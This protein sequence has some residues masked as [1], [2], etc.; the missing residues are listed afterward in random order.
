M[1]TPVPLNDRAVVV[2]IEVATAADSSLGFQRTT[3]EPGG[4]YRFFAGSGPSFWFVEYGV[5]SLGS[6]LDAVT[7]LS[8]MPGTPPDGS[9]LE[10]GTAFV[11]GAGHTLDLR[12]DSRKPVNLLQLLSAADAS[13]T[14]AIDVSHQVLMQQTYQLPA[15]LVALSLR[16]TELA[17]GAQFDWPAGMATTAMLAPIDPTDAGALTP[18]GIN[19]ALSPIAVYLLTVTSIRSDVAPPV[20]PV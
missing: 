4:S 6:Q 17:P 3:I 12:N 20:H 5:L 15:G 7:H 11:V 2:P 14:N 13:S 18:D 19:R 10:A 1:A 9:G 8:I 16:K